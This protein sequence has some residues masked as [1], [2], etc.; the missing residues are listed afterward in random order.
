MLINSVLE[1][2]PLKKYKG[3]EEQMIDLLSQ[4]FIYPTDFEYRVAEITDATESRPDILSYNMYGDDKYGDII[5]KLN[6]ISNP[7]EMSAGTIVIIPTVDSISRFFTT[8]TEDFDDFNEK[9]QLENTMPTPKRKN[10][11]R[12]P[13]E[14][15]MG[16]VRYKI[17]K[18]NKIIYY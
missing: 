4:T 10:E 8:E 5:C 14:A 12:K 9:D 16:D 7:I 6:G 2:K 13:N 18:A 15:V 3:T 17:D 11:R 1:L